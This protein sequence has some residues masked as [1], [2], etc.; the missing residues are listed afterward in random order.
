MRMSCI[1]CGQV[2]SITASQLGGKGRCP[3]CRGEI[4]LPKAT[5]DVPEETEKVEPSHWLQNS[6]SGLL[7]LIFHMVLILI[8]ALI[9]YDSYS[10]EG[11][12]EDVLIGKLPTEKLGESQDEQLKAAEVVSDTSQDFVEPLEA[13]P[14]VDTSSD[15]NSTEE[16]VVASPSTGGGEAA[17]FDL[18]ATTVGGGSMAGGGWEGLLQSLR[19][20]GL[21][22]VLTF[23]STGS[24]QGEIDQVKSQI[25]RIGSTL[26]QLVPKAR[27]SICTYRDQG[28]E[29]VVRGLPLTNDLQQIEHFL[30]GIRA[31]GGGDAPE[32]V[33]EGLRWSIEQN[34]FQPRARKVILVFG[35]APPHRADLPTCLRLASDF[36]GQ[37]KGIVSTVTCRA[38]R[39]LR[40][41]KEIAE[42]GG[43]EAF[44]TTDERQIM[45]QL[46]VLVFGSRHRAKVI[47]AFKLLDEKR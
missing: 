35:D 44:L 32:S 43:G 41:F 24:M 31:D 10:G 25:Q 40:E 15:T 18:G 16:M 23:D 21:D 46:M 12:G 13:E 9:T 27:I 33:Q 17:A 11:L 8:L 19:R 34:T 47:E 26:L 38:H 5:D 20:N 29:Y 37:G 45:T 39:P 30:S 22:I 36:H 3:H 4:R 42:V 14:P 28:D 1:H 2:F 6:M 7:S